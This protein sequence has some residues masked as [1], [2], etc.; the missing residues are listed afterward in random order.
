M[1]GENQTDAQGTWRMHLI[2][3]IDGADG[4]ARSF[5]EGV[6]AAG[7]NGVLCEPNELRRHEHYVKHGLADLR[8]PVV[9]RVT[10]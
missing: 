7:L 9:R 4:D 10:T 8:V 5:D 6:A 1:I 3:E 2:R